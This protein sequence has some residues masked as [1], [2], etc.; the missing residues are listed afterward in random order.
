MLA[1]M[2]FCGLGHWLGGE[3]E[4]PHFLS[5]NFCNFSCFLHCFFTTVRVEKKREKNC[6]MA[7]PKSSLHFRKKGLVFVLPR[8]NESVLCYRSCRLKNAW[9]TQDL[10]GPT[11]TKV[12]HWCLKPLKIDGFLP[13]FAP[14][15]DHKIVVKNSSMP[16]RLAVSNW[17]NS[18]VQIPEFSPWQLLQ[19]CVLFFFL[20]APYF[21]L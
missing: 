13:A 6:W 9:V 8:A 7:L 18:C 14:M 20:F 3:K 4:S 1:M 19:N 17:R 11:K 16:F 2:S 15:Q 21:H 10:F 5:R 12:F